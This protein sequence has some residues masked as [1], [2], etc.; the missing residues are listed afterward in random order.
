VGVNN[1]KFLAVP[2]KEEKI[3]QKKIRDILQQ[4]PLSPNEISVLPYR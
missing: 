3:L 2:F 1:D 4:L